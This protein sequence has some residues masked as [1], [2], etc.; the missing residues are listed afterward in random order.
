[1][2]KLGY[3][4]G[5]SLHATGRECDEAL[6]AILP[7]L[8]IEINEIRDWACCGAT[9]AHAT[10]HLLSVALPAR[11]LALAAEQGFDSILAPCA[12]CFNRLAAARKETADDPALKERVEA[13]LRRPLDPA[14]RVINIAQFLLELIP[15]LKGKTV[16]PLAGLK[17]ACYYGCYLVRPPELNT[18]DDPEAPASMEKVVA[19]LGGNPVS[20]NER[21]TCC[22]AGFSLSRTGSVL[23]LGRQILD[24]ARKAGA[25]AI[26]VGCPMCHS[27]LDMRQ[28]AMA[29]RGE[30][31]GELPVLFLTQ[32]VGLALGMEPRPLGLQR[33][34][35]STA[36]LVERARLQPTD[37]AGVGKS[38]ASFAVTIIDHR[39]STLRPEEVA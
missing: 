1:M 33:H 19:A 27:N 38:A 7:P 32:L 10:N 9:S 18:F 15:V 30:Q 4:P 22:G 11:T 16:R 36:S 24:D 28:R 26:A 34:F 8:G 23:R 3:F 20:W 39:P 2:S 31:T 29:G 5:C 37:P 12:A 35:V 13:I 21:L 17:V 6:K 14:V 25:E